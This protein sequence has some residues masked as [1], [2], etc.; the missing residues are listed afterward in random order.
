[1]VGVTL[2]KEDTL[3]KVTPHLEDTLLKV[4]HPLVVVIPNRVI[5]HKVIPN[6]AILVSQLRIVQ[7]GMGMDLVW[8]VC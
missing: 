4:I 6:K 7:E 8:E 2:P 1:M 5:L 3:L